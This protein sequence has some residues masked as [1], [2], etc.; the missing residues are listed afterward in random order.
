MKRVLLHICCGPCAIYPASLLR[1]EGFQVEG[2][3]YNPNIHP[4]S[5]YRKRYEAVVAASERMD[6]GVLYH[7]YDFENFLKEVSCLRNRDEQHRFCWRIRLEETARAARERGIPYFTTTLLASPYQD[8]EE[9]KHLGDSVAASYGLEF[10]ARDFRKGFALSHQTSREWQLYHQNYCGCV[11][12]ERESIE[13][14]EARKK[15]RSAGS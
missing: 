3:F 5:E 11:Y 9:I 10:L 12:S 15:E 2:F 13:Q 1:T 4:F 6:L 7:K 14:R 8:I